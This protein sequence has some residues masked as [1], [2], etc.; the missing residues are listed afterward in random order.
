[1]P[2]IVNITP[3]TLP[4]AGSPDR[5]GLAI[6]ASD[7]LLRDDMME[8]EAAAAAEKARLDRELQRELLATRGG[9]ELEQIGAR[10]EQAEGLARTEADLFR[11]VRNPAMMARELAGIGA[12]GREARTTAGEEARLRAEVVLPAETEAQSRLI[13]DRG[14]QDRLTTDRT[15]LNRGA[16]DANN[17]ILDDRL[18][19][20]YRNRELDIMEMRYGNSGGYGA[21]GWGGAPGYGR[22]GDA[23]DGDQPAD[24]AGASPGTTRAGETSNGSSRTPPGSAR[25]GG[26]GQSFVQSIFQ[27]GAMS[28]RLRGGGTPGFIQDFEPG[29]RFNAAGRMDEQQMARDST[30]DFDPELASVPIEEHLNLIRSLPTDAVGL[31]LQELPPDVRDAVRTRMGPG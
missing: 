15:F 27:P 30:Y 21:F 17:R 20:P 4:G 11:D 3:R 8:E 16:L 26:V 24:T 28:A 25:G 10:G 14:V 19:S 7:L 22:L 18:E 12:R 31:Y 2:P 6:Q 9:Q 5:L 1:M 13:G 23:E 29:D